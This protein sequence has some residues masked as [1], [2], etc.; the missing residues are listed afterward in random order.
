MGLVPREI[1]RSWS[2]RLSLDWDG[3]MSCRDK[4]MCSWKGLE[5]Y[6]EAFWVVVRN[7]QQVTL[8][9]CTSEKHSVRWKVGNTPEKSEGDNKWV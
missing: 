9:S 3:H 5:K 4:Y 2:L 7:L 1:S 6:R 8:V